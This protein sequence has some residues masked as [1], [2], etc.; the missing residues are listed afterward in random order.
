MTSRRTGTVADASRQ[1]AAAAW[2]EVGSD[3][4]AP[5]TLQVLIEASAVDA[6]GADAVATPSSTEF[7]HWIDAALA[8]ASD[9]SAV[10]LDVGSVLEISVQLVSE[11]VMKGLNDQYRHHDRPTNVLSFPSGL[12]ALSRAGEPALQVLGDIVLCAAV[13]A[14]EA[15]EQYKP[16]T[17]HWAHMTIHGLLHLL[18]HD[19]RDDEQAARMEALEVGTLACLSIDNPYLMQAD[20]RSPH[21][22]D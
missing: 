3:A 5:Y 18:G 20:E 13:I 9:D 12:P 11:E 16:V 7:E 10:P 17:D 19:H 8:R 14:A 21:H 22:D 15:Q 6:A 4:V 2:H 1:R